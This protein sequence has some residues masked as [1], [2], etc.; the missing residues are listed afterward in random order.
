MFVWPRGV[1]RRPCRRDAQTSGSVRRVGAS[2]GGRGGPASG[3]DCHT[4]A[5]GP[6][7]P[8]TNHV[9]PCPAGHVGPAHGVLD[10]GL[11]AVIPLITDDLVRL[12]IVN[13]GLRVFDLLG[14][15]SLDDRPPTSAPCVTATIAPV[16]GRHARAPER[17]V[18]IVGV[19]PVH[20]SDPV[21]PE[22]VGVSIPEAVARPRQKRLGALAGVPA[23]DA[24]SP[25]SPPWRQSSRRPRRVVVAPTRV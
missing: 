13:V 6:R 18:G 1:R 4:P 8:S 9:A 11:I 7:E 20:A 24:E 23:D 21:A 19:R 15:G 25:R 3:D 17:G 5:P 12:R 22:P 2:G 14:R 10:Q 16:S